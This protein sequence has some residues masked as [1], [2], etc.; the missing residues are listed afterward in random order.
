M[1]KICVSK[2][3]ALRPVPAAPGVAQQRTG[4]TLLVAEGRMPVA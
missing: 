2:I 1:S 4:I 3:W